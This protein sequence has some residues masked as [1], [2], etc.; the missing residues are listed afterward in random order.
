[1]AEEVK[2][3]KEELD[4]KEE[5]TSTG[6]TSS[7]ETSQ[8][9]K[10]EK[11][12]QDWWKEAQGRGFKTESDVW[13]SYREAEKK[14]SQM[15]EEL[16]TYKKFE[17]QVSPVLEAIWN[18]EGMLNQLKKSLG[19]QENPGQNIENK[20]ESSNAPVVDKEA[21]SFLM[22]KVIDDFEEKKGIS[23]LDE[24]T[25]KEIRSKIGAEAGKWVG[26]LRKVPLDK[27]PTLLDDAFT[28]ISQKDESVKKLLSDISSSQENANRA[29]MPSTSSVGSGNEGQITLTP[30]QRKVADKMP[31]GAEAYIRGLKKLQGYNIKS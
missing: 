10:E 18:D 28:V 12:L 23:S 26:D 2:E 7:P 20:Q 8:G 19:V 21:R 6:E 25:R 4:K 5:Q 29:A 16:Q 1:M 13:K 14:I 9:D 27:F 22:Q 11:Q 24:Q 17:Q 3:N 30:E 31:G 15:G